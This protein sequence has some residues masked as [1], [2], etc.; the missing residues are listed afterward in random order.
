VFGSS[1]MDQ[2]LIA[3]ARAVKARRGRTSAAVPPL[4]VFTDQDRLPDP[5]AVLAGL[6]KGLC[7]VVLRAGRGVDPAMAQAIARLC[8]SRRFA[9]VV[10]GDPAL[11]IRLRSG[12]HAARGW[13]QRRGLWTAGGRVMTASAHN[14][15]ELVRAI[16]LGVDAVFLSPVFATAS[17]PGA[18]ALGPL[19][20]G[21]RAAS[22]PIPVL[23][24]GGITAA[25]ARRLPPMAAG[26]GVVG[27]AAGGL[28]FARATR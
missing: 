20:W 13:Q 17:H 25:S 2:K 7:G 15:A 4:W 21:V 8:R 16:R 9:L 12:Q 23:A 11:A 14:G 1:A 18:P 26:V 22:C 3:W 24:L 10:A 19:R 28:A 5:R 6:P 27:A